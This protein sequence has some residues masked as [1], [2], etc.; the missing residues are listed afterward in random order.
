MPGRSRSTRTRG[1]AAAALAAGS[2]AS[3]SADRSAARLTRLTVAPLM[4]AEKPERVS[5]TAFSAGSQ[6]ASRVV[7]VRVGAPPG[8]RELADDAPGGEAVEVAGA[9]VAPGCVDA[10]V[11]GHGAGERALVARVA[12]QAAPAVRH[13]RLDAEVDAQETLDTLVDGLRRLLRGGVRVGGALAVRVREPAYR[14]PPVGAL[15]QVLVPPA[16]ADRAG[17]DALGEGRGRDHVQALGAHARRVVRHELRQ[18]AAGGPEHTRAA[19]A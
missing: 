4:R 17:H 10:V 2:R 16:G 18:G 3:A 7:Q 12:D 8:R 11:P 15:L 1:R 19:R 6:D 9:V 13:A 14:D 5:R